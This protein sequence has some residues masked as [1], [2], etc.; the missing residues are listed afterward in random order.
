MLTYKTFYVCLLLSMSSNVG[1]DLL[2]ALE[3]VY[4]VI[5][6]WLFRDRPTLL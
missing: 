6:E 2:E 5:R 4:R 1:N 3:V